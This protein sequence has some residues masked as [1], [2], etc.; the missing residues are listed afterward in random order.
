M[1]WFLWPQG[2]R[3]AACTREV[4]RVSCESGRSRRFSIRVD[5]MASSFPLTRPVVLY[6][7]RQ[8]VSAAAGARKFSPGDKIFQVV[9]RSLS[10]AIVPRWNIGRLFLAAAYSSSTSSTSGHTPV[11]L[12]LSTANHLPRYPPLRPCHP[13]SPATFFFFTGFL[14]SFPFPTS[15]SAV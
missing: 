8:H 1:V 12:P 14:P 11:P 9:A 10:R 2:Q 13:P 6:T 7:L 3:S 5:S 15:S 4:E